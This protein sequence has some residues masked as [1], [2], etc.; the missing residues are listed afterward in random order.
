MRKGVREFALVVAGFAA[1]TALVLRPLPWHLSTLVYNPE[2][3]DGQFSVWNVAWV[4]R[5]IWHQ[6]F[7]VL[8]RWESFSAVLLSAR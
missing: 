2:N 4:A 5:A 1:L 6:P 8:V 3:N 7:H